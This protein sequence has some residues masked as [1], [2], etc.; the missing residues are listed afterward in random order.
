MSDIFMTSTLTP[1][2]HLEIDE[3]TEIVFSDSSPSSWTLSKEDTE[4]ND[5]QTEST[6][7]VVLAYLNPIQDTPNET[8]QQFTYNNIQQNW[9]D[10]YPSHFYQSYQN[11]ETPG[12]TIN[13]TTFST[14]TRP[15]TPHEPPASATSELDTRT[16]AAIL[17]RI[18]E[19]IIHQQQLDATTLE[20]LHISPLEQAA[21][22]ASQLNSATIP[23]KISVLF[24]QNNSTDVAEFDIP[25]PVAPELSVGQYENLIQS[26]SMLTDI[27]D[28]SSYEDRTRFTSFLR[29]SMIRQYE[30]FITPI[31][32]GK[33]RKSRKA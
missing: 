22:V 8:S 32:E 12:P 27:M 11:Y 18:K 16:A 33:V 31:T 23:D 4:E 5:Q 6:N 19:R 3:N 28:Y 10:I 20:S 26:F 25:S 21:K 13:A 30:R 2:C 24:H 7:E 17:L 9:Q 29:R 14:I 1:K 15:Q